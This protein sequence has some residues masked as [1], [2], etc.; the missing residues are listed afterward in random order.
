MTIYN[1]VG[2]SNVEMGNDRLIWKLYLESALETN[3]GKWYLVDMAMSDLALLFYK[4]VTIYH[5]VTLDRYFHSFLYKS[6]VG[7]MI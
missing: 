4:K 3:I 7:K 2:Q 1:V 5:K 6:P